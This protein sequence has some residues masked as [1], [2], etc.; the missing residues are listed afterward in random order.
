MDNRELQETV[1][2]FLHSLDSKLSPIRT[3]FTYHDATHVT[4][5]DRKTLIKA[6]G[7]NLARINDEIR[8]L[9][10]TIKDSVKC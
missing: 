4:D 6:A 10:S 8:Q 2:A 5:A 7:D 9:S 3:Y 1:R